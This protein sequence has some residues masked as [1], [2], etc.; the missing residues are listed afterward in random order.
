MPS[1]NTLPNAERHESFQSII[2]NALTKYGWITSDLCYH[3]HVPLPVKRLLAR[4]D[5]RTSMTIRTRSDRFSAHPDYG[6]FKWEVKT[7]K[8]YGNDFLFEAW[9]FLI[10]SLEHRFGVKCSYF[11]DSCGDR[12][13]AAHVNEMWPLIETYFYTARATEEERQLARKYFPGVSQ[14][15][16]ESFGSGDAFFKIPLFKSSKLE[17]WSLFIER[18]SA[19]SSNAQPAVIA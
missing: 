5:D 4:I 17:D 13:V 1:P 10:H 14:Q 9:P 3:N 6:V 7:A 16:C 15:Y 8:K 2:E 12:K 11:W 18:I 19:K